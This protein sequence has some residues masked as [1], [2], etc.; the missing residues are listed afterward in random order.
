MLSL[1]LCAGPVSKMSY[2]FPPGPFGK[3]FG[4]WLAWSPS[5]DA[6][7]HTA[8]SH[9]AS[10]AFPSLHWV[11]LDWNLLNMSSFSCGFFCPP[12]LLHRTA[13][14]PRGHQVFLL[15]RVTARPTPKGKERH[16]P[17]G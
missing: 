4:M 2:W 1:T 8:H 13:P 17:G 3:L 14:V 9:N 10:G 11:G 7:A 5:T 6:T 16:T 15:L 12:T